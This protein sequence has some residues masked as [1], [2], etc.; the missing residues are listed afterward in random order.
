MIDR[1][2]SK[3]Y[4]RR[5][6]SRA[7]DIIAHGMGLN[8]YNP[9]KKQSC[10]PFHKEKTPSFKWDSDKLFWKCFGCGQTLDIYRYYTEFRGMDFTAAKKEVA[11]M[12]GGEVE[13]SVQTTVVKF[14]KPEIET[15]ELTKA[16]IDYMAL[17]GISKETLQSW[18]V[19]QRRWNNR[20]CYVFQY[21]DE[22]Q[23][24]VFISYREIGK[25]GLKG[26]CEAN[27][28]SILWGMW[29]IDV[30]KP[31][32][33]TEG[34]PDAMAVWES[35]YRNVVSV[36]GG[37]ANC[38]WINHCWD[39]LVIVDE[40]IIFG[41]NDE[42]GL[43]MVEELTNRLGK[44][45]VKV[46]AHEHKDANEVLYRQG[47]EK[48]MELIEAAIAETPKGILDMSRVKYV[49]VKN[50]KHEG[51]PT[52]IKKLDETVDDLHFGELSIL[53]GRNG[54]G[55][56]TM[57]SQIIANSIDSRN[58]V[59]LYS[60]EMSTNRI[61]NWIYRQVVGN[62]EGYLDGVKAKYKFKK[63]VND[64]A[65]E[66]LRKWSSGL[67]FTYDKLVSNVRKNTSDLFE[68]MA[69]AVKR[70]GC[71][72]LIIDNLMSAMEEV[73]ES[74]NSDQSNFVQQC[75]DFCEAYNVHIMLVAH[76]NKSKRHGEKLEK[77]DISGSNNIPNKADIILAID[78]NYKEV[79]DYDVRLRL[80][81]DREEGMFC[82]V[83]FLFKPE[84][85]RLHELEDGTPR[86]IEYGWKKYLETKEWWECELDQTE[87][88]LP[89]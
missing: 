88:D 22:K 4:K 27:T 49:Q 9:S 60:G 75:K 31:V 67:F 16:A 29:D 38:E 18:C 74:L 82:E 42:A 53:Y 72:F 58:P 14:R 52:G 41:D 3:E 71:K 66:A 54:D 37:G 87:L 61:L 50:R 19:K 68:V 76:P 78:R 34:Q 21:F 69:T 43:R 11:G 89:F 56:T 47:K 6:G 63:D 86:A 7:M 12:V 10:C 55:K 39:W 17:R 25:G 79:R 44:Y 30:K 2:L 84:T 5:L 13:L 40:F 70:Y 59:F 36:P 26:G 64:R 23:D 33:I 65:L 35:G 1:D 73:A 81:K 32:V 45:R 62:E 85:K 77:E 28:K 57:V 24:L 48:V 83:M 51:V 8:K 80:L 46:I 15:G 20:D